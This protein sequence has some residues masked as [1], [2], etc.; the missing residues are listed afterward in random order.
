MA[1]EVNIFYAVISIIISLGVFVIIK[2]IFIKKLKNLKGTQKLLG[3]IT[4]GIIISECVFLGLEFNLF[5]IATEFI[6][7]I[8]VGFAL[9][10]FSLQ[11]NLKNAVAGIGIY[12]NPDIDIGDTVE[13]KDR[14]GVIIEIHLTKIVALDEDGTRIYIPTQKFVDDVTFVNHKQREA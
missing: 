13:I 5:E 10:L 14:K 4:V 12:L 6:A 3:L 11:N 1:F 8:G 7:S 9:V 2:I